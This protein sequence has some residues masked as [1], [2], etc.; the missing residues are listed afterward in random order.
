MTTKTKELNGSQQADWNA[1]GGLI[2]GRETI[3][4]LFLILSTPIFSFII[5][6]VV[7]NVPEAS[8]T[9]FLSD[10]LDD[11]DGM[12]AG[13][14]SIIPPPTDPEALRIVACF[15]AF[16]L[17]LQ[18]YM[19][20]EDFV[21][22]V[23]P[24]GNRPVY[25]ANGMASFVCTLFATLLLHAFDLYDITKVYDK[26]PEIISTL[27]VF[28]LM[29]CALLVWKGRVAPSSTDCG[30]NANWIVD[31]YWGVEL[32][33]RVLGWDVKMFTNCRFGM[34]F[35]AVAPIC[36]AAKNIQVNGGNLQFGMFVNVVLQLIYIFKF[37][38]WEMGYMCSMDIQHDRAGYYLCWGCLV[39]VP[40]IYTSQSFYLAEHCPDLPFMTNL[41]IFVAGCLMV[42]I[43]Y[44]A[45]NQ[46][47]VF[48][49]SGG[50]CL[51]WGKVPD[52]IVAEYQTGSNEM[53]KSLLLVGG[54]WSVS[55]HFH[56]IPEILASLCWS[57]PAWNSAFVAPYFY[58]T[59]LT[60]LLIDRSYRDD[61][62]CAK[63]YGTYWS[64]YRSRVPSK[65]IPGIL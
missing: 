40:T 36:F 64:E 65:I 2:P 30:T 32:H 60:I 19:P 18:K 22:T 59:Y 34:M 6:H 56:Y 53:K 61:D 10:L 42:Y 50:K 3:G 39:W 17:V 37:F 49:S 47:A 48:R 7:M 52:K 35:W 1:V 25:K 27:N 57:L 16:Q 23:T 4:P 38:H 15:M 24:A 21:A 33:P 31:Y 43:N 12:I 9:V 28:A 11:P 14:C 58:T 46:R 62:R 8:F 54:W 41:I 55:R 63:K 13:L 45:D 5:I 44:E 26:F 20:G 51:I 29:L